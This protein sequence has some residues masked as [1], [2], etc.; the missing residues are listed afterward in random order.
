MMPATAPAPA[1]LNRGMRLIVLPVALIFLLASPAG[2]ATIRMH[3]EVMS[4]G[5]RTYTYG[6]VTMTAAPG[7]INAVDVAAEPGAV[8][9]ADA[10]APLTGD[11]RCTSTGA[12]TV[13][14]DGSG[15]DGITEVHVELGDGA[16]RATALDPDRIPYL[17]IRGGEGDDALTGRWV[18]L[19]GGD[20]DD[21][22]RGDSGAEVMH[23]DAGND[24]LDGLG[25]GDYLHGG[26]GDDTIRGGDGHD[27]L[28][29]G[30]TIDSGLAAGIDALDGGA[31]NDSLDD[32]DGIGRP[33]PGPD[34]LDGGAGEDSVHS[35][36][37]RRAPVTID[38]RSGRGSGEDGEGDTLTA[39]ENAYGGAGDDT[40]IGDDGPNRLDGDRGRDVIRGGGGDDH[41]TSDVNPR[42]DRPQTAA[43]EYG[44]DRV[45]AGDG[46]DVVETLAALQSEITC[47]SGRDGVGLTASGRARGPLISDTCERLG[48]GRLALDPFPRV[49]TRDSLVFKVFSGKRPRRLALRMKRVRGGR[50][51][52]IVH[53]RFAWRVR[54]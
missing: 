38:L 8:V 26:A 14:C 50:E 35:Y 24:V 54:A 47:G 11:A 13:R 27:N 31:G 34:T 18:S 53:Q 48:L 21:T 42:E 40:L 2:A 4:E 36:A 19:H 29:G 52:L 22:L 43:A 16:D 44:P 33:A 3:D 32:Q 45:S 15:L 23:G 6:V 20:G 25:D 1:R 30:T 41:L 7:E 51:F 5:G 46:N 10:T 17:V 39:I 9:I 28:L 12:N 49:I 37:L